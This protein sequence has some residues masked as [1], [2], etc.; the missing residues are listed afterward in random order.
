MLA[1]LGRRS[2]GR[3]QALRA[4]DGRCNTLEQPLG[5]LLQGLT[6]NSD[7]CCGSDQLAQQG[8]VPMQLLWQALE[9]NPG[10]KNEHPADPACW[11]PTWDSTAPTI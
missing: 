3:G 5:A 4:V 7:D 2:P 1:P 10:P 11:S 9:A 6:P 8:S